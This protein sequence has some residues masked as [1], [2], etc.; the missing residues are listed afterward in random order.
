M[1]ALLT[2]ITLSSNVSIYFTSD[3]G[4]RAILRQYNCMTDGFE[5]NEKEWF[6]VASN[7]V[8]FAPTLAIIIRH[9]QD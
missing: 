8:A 2:I 5:Q 6:Q 3:R 1:A 4:K 7:M 9:K